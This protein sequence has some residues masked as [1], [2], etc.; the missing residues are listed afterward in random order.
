MNESATLGDAR[1]WLASKLREGARCPCCKQLAK[2]YRRPLNA[3][4]TAVLVSAYGRHGDDWYHNSTLIREARLKVGHDS[5]GARYWGLIEEESVRR[6]DGG[7]SG[8]WRLTELGQQFARGEVTV[9][10]YA[11]LYDNEVLRLEGEAISVA[12]SLGEKF[13]YEVLMSG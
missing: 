2:V 9:P 3:S 5:T 6:V 4:M 8:W 10:K 11:L 13:D 1:R 12:E 7:R